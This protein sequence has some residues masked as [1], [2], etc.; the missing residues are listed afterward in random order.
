MVVQPHPA[1]DEGE[2]ATA[3]AATDC[4]RIDQWRN[5]IWNSSVRLQSVPSSQAKNETV[6]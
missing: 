4:T 2:K 6:A 1:D 3:T 5:G